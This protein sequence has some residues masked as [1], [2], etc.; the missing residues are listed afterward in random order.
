MAL[1]G[2]VSDPLKCFRFCI[3]P[4]EGADGSVLEPFSVFSVGLRTEEPGCHR[5]H[6][7]VG[8]APPTPLSVTAHNDACRPYHWRDQFPA[9]NL[10]SPERRRQAL[11]MFGHLFKS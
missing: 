10:P 8:S 3:R 6:A 9:V 4:K 5:P 1:T 7:L 11:Q 2:S